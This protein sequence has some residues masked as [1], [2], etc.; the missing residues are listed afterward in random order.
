MSIWIDRKDANFDTKKKMGVKKRLPTLILGGGISRLDGEKKGIFRTKKSWYHLTPPL[1]FSY[2][3][4]ILSLSPN[5]KKNDWTFSRQ[6]DRCGKRGHQRSSL[7]LKCRLNT[8]QCG[9]HN[10]QTTH[11]NCHTLCDSSFLEK[12]LTRRRKKRSRLPERKKNV[13]IFF[14]S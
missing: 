9:S 3:L 8:P 11:G 4:S 5:R 1:P 13:P 10:L 6:T 14:R 12:E 7:S 2:L